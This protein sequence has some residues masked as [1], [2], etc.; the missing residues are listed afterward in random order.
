L[1]ESAVTH[2]LPAF[3][4]PERLASLSGPKTWKSLGARS[5]LYSGC[6]RHS[7]DRSWIVATV[8]RA[9]WGRAL[10]CC[11]KTLVLRS[12]RH[13]DLIAGR[14][15]FFRRSAYVA[16]LTVFPWACSA[17]RLPSSPKTVSITFPGVPDQVEESLLQN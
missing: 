9:V 8:E 7:K 11:N 6:R 5:G 4:G 1:A 2:A 16:L 12:L 15:W 17:P 3:V 10:S 14:R 13:L